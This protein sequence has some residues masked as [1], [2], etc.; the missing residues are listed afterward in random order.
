MKAKNKSVRLNNVIVSLLVW[1]LIAPTAIIGFLLLAVNGYQTLNTIEKNQQ[2]TVASAISRLD[3]LL[4]NSRQAIMGLVSLAQSQ[5]GELPL[6]LQAVQHSNPI[7]STIYYLN[8]QGKVIN[9]SPFDPSLM[10]LDMSTQPFMA[11][12][13]QPNSSYLSR[14]AISPRTGELTVT[15]VTKLS[16][17]HLLA[18]E[19]DLK[20]IQDLVTVDN[21]SQE[22]PTGEIFI[23][24]EFGNLLAHPQKTL[25]EQQINIK[26]LDL[27]ELIELF[28][29]SGLSKGS[30]GISLTTSGWAKETHW[31][32]TAQLPLKL[33]LGPYLITSTILFV[34][35]LSLWG[36][37]VTRIRNR[38]I[39]EIAT[40]LS[41]L[42]RAVK[43]L[44][45]GDFSTPTYPLKIPE[46]IREIKELSEEFQQM[47]RA[48]QIR[49][50]A[51]LKSEEQEH[52]QRILAEALR[53]TAGALNSTLNFS[54]VL[55]RILGNVGQ[56]VPHDSS[57]IILLD[58]DEETVHVLAK[59]GG[60]PGS[61]SEL[62]L[63]DPTLKI[64]KI[65]TLTKMYHTGEPLV[66]PDTMLESSWPKDGESA[67]IQSYAGAPIKIKNR[68]IGFIILNSNT[69]GFYN[70]EIA[71]RLQAFADQAGMALNNARLLQELQQAY[72]KTLQGWSKALELR[73]YETE[74]HTIR[75]VEMTE[76]L[77]IRL[78]VKEPELTYLRYGSLLHDIGKIGIPDSILLKQGPL[79]PEEWQIMRQHPQ[80]AFEIL[81]PIPYLRQSIDIPFCHH[82]KWDGSG[83]PRGLKGEEIPFA[84]RIFAVMDVW[85]GL[86][87]RRPYHEPWSEDEALA[88]IKTNSG[89]QFDPKVVSEF[90]KFYEEELKHLSNYYRS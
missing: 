82:E 80:H 72:D 13:D 31:L 78:G 87:S 25:V 88:Y 59:K 46:K 10:N 61:K 60:Q 44:S 15:L 35:L 63:Q 19:I 90:L 54:E 29:I 48:I 56:V 30:S 65:P 22:F 73:D 83:Y 42:S 7:F 26:D 45:N 21:A 77:A 38:L 67:W 84:A 37:V 62:S 75:V 57:H 5:P 58:E 71:D 79:S 23:S 1:Q 9:L 76:R 47:S 41:N 89:I 55:E 69:P 6:Y 39:E 4:K 16:D 34:V 64:S 27:I 40:P 53:D 50:V 36:L 33:A 24:D 66:I 17:E 11:V 86:V 2:Q 74:G 81:A 43:L 32:V 12:V 68:T 8:P 49:Q 52:Q 20:K 18:A 85:D 51:L 14:P 70:Q 28:K 3:D